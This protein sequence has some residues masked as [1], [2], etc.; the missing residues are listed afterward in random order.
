LGNLALLGPSG[1][2]KS[3]A[4]DLLGKKLFKVKMPDGKVIYNIKEW[5]MSQSGNI[6]TVR[7]D[8]MRYCSNQA[9]GGGR[10][11]AIFTEADNITF[12][13]QQSLRRPMEIYKDRIVFI[14]TANYKGRIIQPIISRCCPMEFSII[15]D[16]DVRKFVDK[17]INGEGIESTQD[18]D[19]FEHQIQGL[20]KE[21]RGDLRAAASLLE[22]WVSNKKLFYKSRAGLKEKIVTIFGDLCAGQLNAALDT[23]NETLT[24][25]QDRTIVQE[26]AETIRDSKMPENLK[27]RCLISCAE[28]DRDLVEG[29]YTYTAMYALTSKLMVVVN[30]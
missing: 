5:D 12:A 8:I 21:A 28:A 19:K 2:G 7:T 30:K 24:T 4:A 29:V 25:T 20:V 14:I 15:P 23:I 26:L 3:L 6:D 17:V 22:G 10:K 11:L 16:E 27:A 1:V 18:D 9:V 13:A